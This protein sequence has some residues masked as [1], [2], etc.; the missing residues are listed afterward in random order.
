[1]R[2]TPV[3]KPQVLTLVRKHKKAYAKIG[4]NLRE[5]DIAAATDEQILGHFLG[6]DG[7]RM[8][9]PVLS[10]GM[11]IIAGCDEEMYRRMTRG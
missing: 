10:N 6:R 7:D 8:R 2:K 3:L 1:M 11:V 5:L 9:A 4:P